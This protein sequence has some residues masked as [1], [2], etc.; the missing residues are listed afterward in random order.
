M[1]KTAARRK[2]SPPKLPVVPRPTI[3]LMAWRNLRGLTQMEL[4]DLSGVNHGTISKIENGKEW[5]E[6]GTLQRLAAGLMLNDAA[7]LFRDPADATGVW[8][9]AE[10]LA[11]LPAGDRA[12]LMRMMDAYIEDANTI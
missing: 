12:K 3:Y 1:P 9:F 6:P 8:A 4:N 2:A 10:K 5:P 7:S 11:E